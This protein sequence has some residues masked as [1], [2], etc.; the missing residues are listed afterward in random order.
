MGL[1]ILLHNL[2]SIQARAVGGTVVSALSKVVT[3]FPLLLSLTLCVVNCRFSNNSASVSALGGAI[4]LL[5]GDLSV[6]NCV[7]VGNSADY[8]GAVRCQSATVSPLPMQGRL[9][10]RHS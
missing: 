7:F 4:Y 2:Q 8:G 5:T 1:I 10:E 3:G 6:T 9:S